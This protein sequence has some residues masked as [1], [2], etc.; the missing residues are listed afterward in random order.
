MIIKILITLGLLVTG[1]IFLLPKHQQIEGTWVLENKN[2]T[3]ETAVLR[4][5]FGEGYYV[6]KLDIP[7]QQ[8][9]D[10]PVFLQIK[11]DS[12][13]VRIDEKGD[14]FVAAIIKDS[15]MIGR[16]VVDGRSE[17]VSFRKLK[18]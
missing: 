16:S 9:F 2:K 17:D 6:A 4:I 10:N 12:I 18:N 7:G 3:C 8:V 11:N 13:R 14:C 1:T 5:Q 15:L